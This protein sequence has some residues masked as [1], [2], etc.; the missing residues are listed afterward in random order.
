[1]RKI[2]AFTLLLLL[3]LSAGAQINFDVSTWE[4]GIHQNMLITNLTFSVGKSPSELK[5]YVFTSAEW[6]LTDNWGI[7][8]G[9]FFN[10]GSSE[11]DV[12]PLLNTCCAVDP[13]TEDYYTHNLFFGPNY[14]FLTRKRVDFYVGVHPGL[15]LF[16]APAF[17]YAN[18]DGGSVDVERN[19][20]ISPAAS[21]QT[22]LAYYA[23][24]FHAFLN[25]RYVL[26]RHD[27]ALY[28][29]KFNEMRFMLGLGFNL[30]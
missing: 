29:G 1:M 13:Q 30:F 26:G 2:T 19:Y 17:T 28:E 5:Y 6:T 10:V 20:G 4:T 16:T 11:K 7:E 14:H 12:I 18:T 3:K 25:T 27:S 24:F 9:L 21:F 22:G 23:K 8:G 15:Q